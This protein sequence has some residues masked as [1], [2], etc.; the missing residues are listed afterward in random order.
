MVQNGTTSDLEAIRGLYE[1]MLR[2]WN[3][4]DAGAYA[5]GFA[6]DGQAIGFDGSWHG[7]RD[8]IEAEIG[9][10]FTAHPGTGRYVWL[11]REIRLIADLAAVLRA[12]AGIVSGSEATVN[13]RVNSV[14]TLVAE[15]VS[16]SWRIVLFQNTPA[17][18]H[19][20]PGHVADLTNAL[21]EV[22]RNGG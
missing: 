13:P 17:A 8:R 19:G 7:G 9:A 14:Q 15:K 18:F 20:R 22:V 5:E 21:N 16:G 10:I 1:T 3:A 12:D 11:I 6:P 4:R 2:G